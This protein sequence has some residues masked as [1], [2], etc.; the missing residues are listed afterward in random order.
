VADLAICPN[1]ENL[2]PPGSTH[3]AYCGVELTADGSLANPPIETV[4]ETPIV[5]SGV[6]TAASSLQDTLRNANLPETDYAEPWS[7]AQ[8]NR[9]DDLNQGMVARPT[10]SVTQPYATSSAA[11]STSFL[12]GLLGFIMPPAGFILWL[13]WH[14]THPKRAKTALIGAVLGLVFGGGFFGRTGGWYY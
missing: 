3:C 13:M 12:W 7:P 11:D 5:A 14:R 2:I 9:I 10:Y 8:L 1:C 4:T 6:T